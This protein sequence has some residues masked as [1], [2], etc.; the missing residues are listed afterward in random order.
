MSQP[1]P[2]EWFIR[3]ART[4]ALVA[5]LF[6]S[7]LALAAVVNLLAGELMTAVVAGVGVVVAV[8]PA[9]VKR[10]WQRTIPWP[11]L[12]LT[13][14]PFALGAVRLP[15]AAGFVRSGSVAT[16]AL[17]VVVALQL[18]TTVRMT[19]DFA[20]WFSVVATLG[21]A[22]IWTFCAWLS[23]EYFGTT[24]F[25]TNTELMMFF[26]ATFVAGIVVAGVFRWYFGRRL[27]ENVQDRAIEEGVV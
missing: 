24:F 25:Q 8:V 5:W 17:L 10:S 15:F 20:V 9:W 7:V 19:P 13:V 22:G 16:L 27:R 21:T 11:L 6:V 3:D 1:L 14:L 18:T 4:N 2:E 23:A 26:L 12:A